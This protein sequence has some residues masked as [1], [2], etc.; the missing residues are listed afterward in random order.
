MRTLKV[1]AYVAFVVAFALEVVAIPFIPRATVPRGVNTRIDAV[2]SGVR[3]SKTRVRT[4]VSE[5][6]SV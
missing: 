1:V 4:R 2:W 6:V 3:A 5:V